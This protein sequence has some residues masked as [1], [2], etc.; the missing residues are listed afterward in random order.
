M[1]PR[2]VEPLNLKLIYATLGG[3]LHPRGWVRS[4]KSGHRLLKNLLHRLRAALS[5]LRD[6]SLTEFPLVQVLQNFL[7]LGFVQELVVRLCGVF[8][9]TQLSTLH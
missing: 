8:G 1:G 3:G 5:N 2:G 4:V 6:L 7:R 9:A